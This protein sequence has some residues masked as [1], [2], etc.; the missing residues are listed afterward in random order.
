MAQTLEDGGT[1]AAAARRYGVQPN[2]LSVWCRL[3]KSGQSVLPMRQ[4]DEVAPLVAPL[5]VQD[6]R[7]CAGG[8][9]RPLSAKYLGRDFLEISDAFC[10]A[11]D[12]LLHA[13]QRLLARYNPVRSSWLR[14]GIAAAFHDLE[15][16]SLLYDLQIIYC[17]YD[18]K[19]IS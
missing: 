17:L 14:R 15:I 11:R 5:V 18:L 10:P 2:Q 12:I 9:S 8:S 4:S 13:V 7:D 1:V 16:R 19:I 6:M 3:G